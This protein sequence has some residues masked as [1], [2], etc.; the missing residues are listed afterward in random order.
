MSL[1]ENFTNEA[2]ESRLFFFCRLQQTSKRKVGKQI[3]PTEPAKQ[4]IYTFFPHQN[5]RYIH[6]HEQS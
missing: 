4:P 1:V 3:L 5:H 2:T 6:I